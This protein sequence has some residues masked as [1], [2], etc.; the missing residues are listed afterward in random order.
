MHADSASS[1]M[2]DVRM[3]QRRPVIAEARLSG[4]ARALAIC[5]PDCV[6]TL[7]LGTPLYVEFGPLNLRW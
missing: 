7:R 5:T 1:R 4:L 6:C 2:W 3:E